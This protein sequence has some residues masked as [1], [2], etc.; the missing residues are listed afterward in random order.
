MTPPLY[1]GCCEWCGV[2]VLPDRNTCGPRCEAALQVAEKTVA[3]R[4]LAELKLWRRHRGR[5][6]TPGE[7]AM[8]RLAALTDAHLAESRARRDRMIKERWQAAQAKADA[9]A[10]K[11]KENEL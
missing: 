10:A 11:D 4:A 5:K 3:R 9:A 1:P 2:D 8:T 6:G 7:G